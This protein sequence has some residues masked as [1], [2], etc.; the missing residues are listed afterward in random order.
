MHNAFWLLFDTG[1]VH[2]AVTNAVNIGCKAF[3]LFLKSQRKW[4]AKPLDADVITKFKTAIKVI[5]I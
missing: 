1:G 4:N 3:A 5:T 2:N